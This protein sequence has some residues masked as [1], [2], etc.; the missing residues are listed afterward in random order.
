MVSVGR[1]LLDDF[2]WTI[3]VDDDSRGWHLMMTKLSTSNLNV[4]D[5]MK[6]SQDPKSTKLDFKDPKSTKLDFKDPKSTK[7]DF[8]HKL[9]S[10]LQ[11]TKRHLLETCLAANANRVRCF[12]L[13]INWRLETSA[14]LHLFQHV[15]TSCYILWHFSIIWTFSSKVKLSE[16]INFKLRFK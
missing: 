11:L 7:L 10:K 12:N 5:I 13:L 14:L 6:Q 1:F 9:S 16:A 4:L 15:S 8:R 2:W 3:L